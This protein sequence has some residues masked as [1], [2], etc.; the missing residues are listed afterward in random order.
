MTKERRVFMTPPR[1]VTKADINTFANTFLTP[2]L[3]GR[4]REA[5][6]TMILPIID[7]LYEAVRWHGLD[8]EMKR[9]RKNLVGD[10]PATTEVSLGWTNWKLYKPLK[11]GDTVT[12]EI[13]IVDA[14]ASKNRSGMAIIK[15]RKVAYDQNGEK[16]VDV[17]HTIGIF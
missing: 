4:G 13:K 9:V 16:I 3:R 10:R 7:G 2:L 6:A 17:D 5:H 1:T 11:A 8:A 14:R 12:M 15:L